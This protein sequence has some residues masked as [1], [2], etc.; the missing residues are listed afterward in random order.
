MFRKLTL[1]IVF[2]IGLLSLSVAT[3]SNQI[4]NE[5]VASWGR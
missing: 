1:T 5:A 2:S 3:N 4:I